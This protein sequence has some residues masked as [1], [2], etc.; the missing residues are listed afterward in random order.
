MFNRILF[1]SPSFSGFTRVNLP[2]FKQT[3]LILNIPVLNIA[4]GNVDNDEPF[5]EKEILLP[6]THIRQGPGKQGREKIVM[7]LNH[8]LQI[9]DEK[10]KTIFDITETIHVG[11]LLVD[12]IQD[13]AN[14]RRGV[15][16]AHRVYGVPMTINAAGHIYFL[17]LSK[18]S[19]IDRRI[20]EILSNECL[21]G[22]R[23]QGVDIYWRENFICP[24]E[25]QY[26][27]MVKRK[28]GIFFNMNYRLMQ[29][30]S[31]N[32]TDYSKLVNMIGCYFQ[33]RDDYC[34]LVHPEELEEWP[35]KE[36]AEDS[37]KGSNFC[38]DIT[39]GKFSFP[40]IHAL[41]KP[42]GAEI[43]NILKQRTRDVSL[44][45]Y[46]VSLLNTL[47]S[48]QYT[49]NVME[50]MDREARAM[51]SKFGGNPLLETALDEL[52]NWKTD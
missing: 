43:L 22:V 5:M 38:D 40:V 6:Y 8:W 50:E 14:M 35:K 42:Q 45:K 39:E 34:N 21:N 15:P 25:E 2:T 3:N 36:D 28:T 1:K 32:K 46:F 51:I 13:N 16:A 31:E 48:L 26:M 37:L 20:P 27:E 44:K 24:T 47:G 49:R 33:I 4:C 11:N 9:S 10:L 29:L 12:D 23:G 19:K 52:L 41:Q 18:A 17:T 30:F 7:A